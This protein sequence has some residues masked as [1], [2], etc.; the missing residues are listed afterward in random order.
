MIWLV[1]ISW[2]VAWSSPLI[3]CCVGADEVWAGASASCCSVL[4]IRGSCSSAA[5]L[6]D[7]A[8][9]GA[10]PRGT[11]LDPAAFLIRYSGGALV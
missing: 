3:R 2:I 7:P 5:A 9:G 10:L 11:A 8:W 6:V 1:Q 4:G